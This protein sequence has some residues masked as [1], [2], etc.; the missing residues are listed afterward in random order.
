MF[1]KFMTLEVL[2]DK[3][4]MVAFC[5]IPEIIELVKKIPKYSAPFRP[6]IDETA[7]EDINNIMEKC[8]NEVPLDRPMF[9]ALK[10]QIR[11]INR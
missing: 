6:K 4:S 11:K 9:S 5:F 2:E 1:L 3:F 7:F 10:L 8:W